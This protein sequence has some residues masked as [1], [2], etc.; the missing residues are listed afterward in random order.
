MT[1]VNTNEIDYAIITPETIDEMVI[2]S[3][4][5][6]LFNIQITKKGFYDGIFHYMGESINTERKY[7]KG[8]KAY[9]KPYITIFTKNNKQ[10]VYYFN[11]TEHLNEFIVNNNI[12]VENNFIKF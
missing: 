10:L 2:Y 9:L 7:S 12:T 8:K 11:S 4:G 5:I 6:K 1:Y 3:K